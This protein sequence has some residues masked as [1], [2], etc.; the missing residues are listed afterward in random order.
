MRPPW[1]RRD[2]GEGEPSV[3]AA[4]VRFAVAG[5]VAVALVGLASFL[6]M[7][8]IGTSE[9]TDNASEVT[10]LIGEGVVQ[11]NLTQGLI[12]GDPAAIERFDQLI[13][14]TVLIGP[15]VRVK[16]WSADGSDRLLRRAAPD[17]PDVRARRAAS[18]GPSAPG[19]RT[20]T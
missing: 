19:R 12:D 6:L 3:S 15:I 17:R 5:L 16:L 13:Q 9:A 14:R 7:R 1:R 4:V 20:R 2:G 10:R 18:S 11:P 8:R